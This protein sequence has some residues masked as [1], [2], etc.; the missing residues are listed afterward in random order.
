MTKFIYIRQFLIAV[1][2]R[3]FKM[4]PRMV[5][6]RLK[7]LRRLFNPLP[8]KMRSML[9]SS[10]TLIQ[11]SPLRGVVDAYLQRRQFKIGE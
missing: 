5:E 4:G 7:T 1:V 11:F 9:K 10:A 3:F 2:R 6:R 8:G